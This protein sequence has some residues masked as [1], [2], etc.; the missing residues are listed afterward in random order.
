MIAI[1][2][3][4]DLAFAMRLI[5]LLHDPDDNAAPVNQ[6]R[7]PL[8]ITIQEQSILITSK[9][10]GPSPQMEIEIAAEV[11]GK[12]PLSVAIHQSAL[13]LL[14]SVPG[15]SVTLSFEV[16]TGPTLN[17]RATGTNGGALVSTLSLKG[18][19]TTPITIPDRLVLR[20]GL[21]VFFAA[22]RFAAKGAG[23]PVDLEYKGINHVRIAPYGDKLVISGTNAVIWNRVQCGGMLHEESQL[24]MRPDAARLIHLLYL[25]LNTRPGF[26]TYSMY[27]DRRA[28]MPHR[29]DGGV[30]E[31]VLDTAGLTDIPATN[32][33]VRL[34]HA[35]LN[36]LVYPAVAAGFDLPQTTLIT[37][38]ELR[39][40]MLSQLF[41]QIRVAGVNEGGCRI[42]FMPDKLA[43]CIGDFKVAINREADQ[44]PN[45]ITAVLPV[46]DPLLKRDFMTSF[47][48]ALINANLRLINTLF[49]GKKSLALSHSTSGGYILECVS[50]SP[51]EI[52]ACSIMSWADW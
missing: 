28:T 33:T 7:P 24:F 30:S 29:L 3:A 9:P 4:A 15:P 37:R 12:P 39:G 6:D 47:N 22:L 5:N 1:V 10:R 17:L 36:D 23:K 41:E 31:F 44:R 38:R 20:Q 19:D 26:L 46:G 25:A 48:G 51:D 35:L 50:D 21:Q 8:L 13:R 16:S 14:T 34:K 42:D 2:D 49:R 27:A 40:G 18:F 32:V 45:S 43:V 52:A 11:T